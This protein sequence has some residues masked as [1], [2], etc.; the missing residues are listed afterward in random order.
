MKIITFDSGFSFDDPNN[1][2]GDPSYQL[3]PGDPG[4]VPPALPINQPPTKRKRMK[5]NTY[6]PIRM[7]DQINWLV[8]FMN[9]LPAY[10]ATL[11]LTPA[12]V[13]AAVADAGW[14]VYVLQSWL[15]AA[16]AWAQDGRAHG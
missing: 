10:T 9:K 16:R 14:L 3:E 1:R 4:Y 15:R 6:F 2:W 12:Q 8:N 7:A 11:G 13:T 5:R